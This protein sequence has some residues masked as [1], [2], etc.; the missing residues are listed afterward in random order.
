MRFVTP[1]ASSL[2]FLLWMTALAAEDK[3]AFSAR[4]EMWRAKL[5]GM[6]FDYPD[7]ELGLLSS[8]A[9]FDGE[10]QLHIVYDPKKRR[11]IEY[12][13]V[14]DGRVIIALHGHDD[15]RLLTF[16][17]HLY[18]AANPSD[19]AGCAIESYNMETGKRE[20]RTELHQEQPGSHS[21]YRNSVTMWVSGKEEAGD[22]PEGAAIVVMGSESYC[23]YVE[24]LDRQTGESLAVKNFRVG[25]RKITRKDIERSLQKGEDST[26]SK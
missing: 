19:S 9:E 23:D 13:V 6:Q 20:W 25:F 2:C 3:P 22:E 26:D 7:D 24:V 5:E 14:R 11:A 1:I 17:N 16:D 15:S 8:M 18:F 4:Q 10:G 12:Q 21:G